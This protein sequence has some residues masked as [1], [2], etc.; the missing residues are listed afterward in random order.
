M[1]EGESEACHGFFATKFSI[2]WRTQQLATRMQLS[3]LSHRRLE[4]CIF[5]SRK[6]FII[7]S[8][9][10][11]TYH[12]P[13]ITTEALDAYQ[14]VITTGLV[15]F[16]L[17]K[18]L[19]CIFEVSCHAV[20]LSCIWNSVGTVSTFTP[21]FIEVLNSCWRSWGLSAHFLASAGFPCK[22]SLL[23]RSCSFYDR[24]FVSYFVVCETFNWQYDS[25]LAVWCYS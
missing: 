17:S 20:N 8:A 22:F 19:N 2:F 23:D 14:Q 5:F 13:C 10:G 11:N 3:S 25:L 21:G 4:L 6:L 16:K 18:I 1:D 7:M 24:I 12:L 9:F 15:K